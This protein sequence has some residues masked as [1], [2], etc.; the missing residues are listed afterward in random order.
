MHGELGVVNRRC[1]LLQEL[2]VHPAE[3]VNKT[4]RLIRLNIFIQQVVTR[5]L[6]NVPN[7]LRVDMSSNSRQFE[8][9]CNRVVVLEWIVFFILSDTV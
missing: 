4:L 1:F 2:L 3:P 8:T 5:Y 7:N 6:W 9:Y